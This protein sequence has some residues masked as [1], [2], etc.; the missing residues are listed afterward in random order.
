MIKCAWYEAALIK[1]ATVDPE[2]AASPAWALLHPGLYGAM[3]NRE[4]AAAAGEKGGYPGL[5][6][7][8]GGTA[9][10]V[11]GGIGG[12]VIGGGL[13]AGAGALVGA[14]ARNPELGK[15]LSAILGIGGGVAGSTAG[16]LGLP[17]AIYK[18]EAQAQ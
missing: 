16:S 11:A 15:R 2:N 4:D 9:A 13:G 6:G 18:P 8:L 5:R 10:G 12:G 14:L 3:R 7:L 17:Y 1:Q